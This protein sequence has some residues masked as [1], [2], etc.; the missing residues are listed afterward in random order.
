MGQTAIGRPR[1]TP[2]FED[3]SPTVF[4]TFGQSLA[5]RGKGRINTLLDLL[6]GSTPE[7]E[8][9]NAVSS[10]MP[11]GMVVGPVRRGISQAAGRTARRKPKMIFRERNQ[12]IQVEGLSPGGNLTKSL[13]RKGFVYRGMTEEE[14]EA[15]VGKTGM[16]QSRGDYSFP[17]EG[18]VFSDQ[19]GEAENFVNSGRTDPSKTGRNTYIVEVSLSDSPNLTRSPEGYFKSG[20]SNRPVG[21]VRRAWQVS[22]SVEN[23]LVAYP[24]PEPLQRRR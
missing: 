23:E 14:Y 13:Q 7:E 18:T 22:P 21:P 3:T 1:L 11:G 9:Q 12:D 20:K 2:R 24:V 10:L 17:E 4:D 6:S 19:I 15:T 5:R 8:A 16:V